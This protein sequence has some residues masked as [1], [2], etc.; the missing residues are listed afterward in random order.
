MTVLSD[1]LSTISRNNNWH[2]EKIKTWKIAFKLNEKVC[3]AFISEI[4]VMLEY[5][6]ETW[7]YSTLNL[8]QST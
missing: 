5:Y 1:I 7:S 3:V 8:I 4:N 6:F 2:C